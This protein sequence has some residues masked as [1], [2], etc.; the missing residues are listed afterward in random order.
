MST[1]GIRT[2]QRNPVLGKKIVHPVEDGK[3]KITNRFSAL[4][5]FGNSLAPGTLE[6]FICGPSP[7]GI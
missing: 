7:C 5:S 1:S 2:T 4:N 6:Q 3:T